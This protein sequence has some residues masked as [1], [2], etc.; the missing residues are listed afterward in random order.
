MRG[1]G[2]KREAKREGDTGNE[3]GEAGEAERWGRRERAW[4]RR[5]VRVDWR[6]PGQGGG[7]RPG[8]QDGRQGWETGV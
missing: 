7:V 6:G 8:G 1:E 5:H 2:D 4:G 3:V